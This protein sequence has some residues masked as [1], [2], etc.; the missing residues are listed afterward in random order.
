MDVPLLNRT[1]ILHFF[2]SF[3]A[4]LTQHLDH[5]SSNLFLMDF[6]TRRK[7][8]PILS[9]KCGIN[10]GSYNNRKDTSGILAENPVLKLPPCLK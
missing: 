10:A 2:L 6:M 1:F 7:N 8:P 9:P 5:S 3:A 4:A